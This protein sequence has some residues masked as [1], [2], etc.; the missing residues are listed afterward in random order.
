MHF[1]II[2]HLDG[3][4]LYYDPFEPLHLDG[5]LAWDLAP[6]QGLRDCTS[7]DDAPGDVA[8]PLL[9]HGERAGPWVWRASALFPD[10]PT[11]E[12]LQFLRSRFRV[13]RAELTTGSPN[14][15]GSAYRGRNI[16]VPLLLA[17]RLVAYA[18]GDR[19][20]ALKVCRRIRAL[21]K[22]RGAGYGKIIGVDAEPMDA[23]RS[24]IWQGRAMRWLPHPAGTRLV[25]PR[26]PYWNSHGRVPCI[27]PG[28]P[29]PPA[30]A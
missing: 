23:D 3:S 22:Y 7:A 20:A 28:D 6:R 15:A 17:R 4:G 8:L 14:L 25:R 16:P 2:F 13:A 21:G 11:G 24:L 27:A 5:I 10:G 18:S 1:R 26:P 19:R 30:G 12:D 29:W 9:R